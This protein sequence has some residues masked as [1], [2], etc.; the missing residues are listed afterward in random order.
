M[1]RVAIVSALSEENRYLHEYLSQRNNWVKIGENLYEN[2]KINV[3]VFAKIL[4]V[5]KVNAAFQTADVI[6]EFNPDLIVNI[7]VSGGLA[8]NVKRG[9]I[10]I[11]TE[12]VQTDLKPF[13]AVNYPKIDGTSEEIVA[14]LEKTARK[15]G[16]DYVTGKLATGDFFLHDPEE[17]QRI[18]DDFQPVS[19]DMETAAIAQV[20]TA[21]EVEM[22]AIRIFS[23]LADEKAGGLFLQ[24]EIS[25]SE[26]SVREKLNKRP[27]ELIISY[28]EQEW[29]KLCG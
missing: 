18:I 26:K 19:F 12:Y 1:K 27:T 21:K 16:F 5:G 15:K 2:K 10:A 8:P 23:D 9:T 11:G 17:R 7:G 25:K 20:A 24:K 13:L 4:G 28:L 6:H 22:A 14:G 3:L 29:K